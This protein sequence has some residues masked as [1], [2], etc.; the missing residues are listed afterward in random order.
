MFND[1]L[2]KLKP[3]TKVGETVRLSTKDK[4]VHGSKLFWS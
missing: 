3:K 4:I 2:R 1:E